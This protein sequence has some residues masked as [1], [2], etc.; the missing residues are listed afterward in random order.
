MGKNYK[1]TGSFEDHYNNV[2]KAR[3][4]G[5]EIVWGSDETLLLDLDTPEQVDRYNQT[6]KWLFRVLDAHEEE[7]WTSKM[8]ILTL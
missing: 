3:E 8:V 5:F 6:K 4:E 7:T 2:S 1:F